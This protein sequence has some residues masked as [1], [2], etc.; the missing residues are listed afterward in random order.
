MTVT[1]PPP[2]KQS[3][4]YVIPAMYDGTRSARV[5]V[6][7]K[8][9]A[10]GVLQFIKSYDPNPTKQSKR[11]KAKALRAG[12]VK[13]DI[14]APKPVSGWKQLVKA[15]TIVPPPLPPPS[16]APQPPPAAGK[17]RAPEGLSEGA[18]LPPQRQYA[19]LATQLP[20]PPPLTHVRIPSGSRGDLPPIVIS[21]LPNE[22]VIIDD[23]RHHNGRGDPYESSDARHRSGS[24]NTSGLGLSALMHEREDG[25]VSDIDVDQDHPRSTTGSRDEGVYGREDPDSWLHGLPQVRYGPKRR[26]EPG[27]SP[28]FFPPCD[29]Y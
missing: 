28:A 20:P 11:A 2:G 24:G 21:P 6:A 9:S 16:T 26:A 12:K 7:L 25:E 29:E 15:Q 18:S 4:T 1:L 17:F 3:K 23:C 19:I 22:M 8:A 10:M 27:S 14:A 5:A 13:E